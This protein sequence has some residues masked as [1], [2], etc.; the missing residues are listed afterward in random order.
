[1]SSMPLYGIYLY[2]IVWLRWGLC[3]NTTFNASLGECT[4]TQLQ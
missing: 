1:M 3:M 4:P 2:G